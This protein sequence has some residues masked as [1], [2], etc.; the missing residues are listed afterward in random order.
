MKRVVKR[1]G[2]SEAYDRKK[3]QASVYAAALSVREHP[4][5]AHKTAA[6]VA[7]YVDDWLEH[8]HEVTTEDIRRKAGERLKEIHPDAAQVFNHHRVIWE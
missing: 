1:A 7:Q 8:H 2:H 4:D 3:L 6:D 5:Q